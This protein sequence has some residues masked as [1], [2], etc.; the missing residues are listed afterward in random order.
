M[1]REVSPGVTVDLLANGKDLLNVDGEELGHFFNKVLTALDENDT[2]V[3]GGELLATADKAF[4]N[5]VNFRTEVGA[6]FNRLE[7]AKDRNETE[8]LNLKIC[9][10]IKKMLILLKNIWNTLWK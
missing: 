1:P 7:A 8:N 6:T 9:D 10:Q 5:T 3:L 4:E 2:D